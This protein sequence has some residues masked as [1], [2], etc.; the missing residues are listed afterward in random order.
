M[1]TL[2]RDIRHTRFYKDVVEENR[3]RIELSSGLKLLR[4]MLDEGGISQDYYDRKV[5]E[6]Q[7]QAVPHEGKS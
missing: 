7:E 1:T 2:V 3:P 5:A 6:L 4:R